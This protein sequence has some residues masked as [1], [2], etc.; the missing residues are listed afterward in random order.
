M[1]RIL[2]SILVACTFL[3]LPLAE[4]AMSPIG[5]AIVPPVQFPGHDFSITGLRLSALWGNNRNVYGFDFGAIGNMTEGQMTGISAS[6]IFN[7][8]KG[9]TTG[10]LLQAAG[11]ANFNQG[12][13]NIYGIQLAGIMNNNKAESV[14]GGLMI[15]PINLGAYT[16]IRG[17][18]VGLYNKAHDVVGFQIGVINDCDNLHGIQIG[19]I[20]FHRQGLFSVAPILNVG[21]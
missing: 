16:K 9:A 15:A 12:K 18:Q 6:G 3:T 5:I 20:N 21:F 8:N 17:A 4:A 7:L 1:K 13:A 2:S 10:I 14:V 11:L 19:L